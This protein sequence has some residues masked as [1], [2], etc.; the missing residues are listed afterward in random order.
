MP[1]ILF[2]AVGLA[3]DS[4]GASVALGSISNKKS[5][6]QGLISSAMFGG[7]QAI[8][9]LI[10]WLIG[11]MFKSSISGIDHWLAFFL[12]SG[13]GLK[14]AYSDLKN[15]KNR[16]EQKKVSFRLITSLA[17][18]T[19]ID[20]LIVGMSITLLNISMLS[21]VSI[22]GIVTFLLSMTGIYLGAKC[23]GIFKNK[24]G[25]LGGAILIIIGAKILTDHLFS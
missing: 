18:A 4:F 19:S 1:Y 2:I 21:A 12:L 25:L 15:K 16:L 3:M 8:M 10:G 7:F 14:M 23:S 5:F 22:I 24:T 6:K 17:F 13:I 20:A 9:P 11:E